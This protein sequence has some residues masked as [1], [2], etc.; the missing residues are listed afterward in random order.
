MKCP[1][2]EESLQKLSEGFFECLSCDKYFERHSED[3]DLHECQVRY[4]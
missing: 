2:C 4:D 1:N 3:E